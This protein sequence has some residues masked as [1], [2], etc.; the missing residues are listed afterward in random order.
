MAFDYKTNLHDPI[1]AALGVPAVLTGSTAVGSHDLVVIDR[2]VGLSVPT[3][4]VIEIQSVRPYCKVRMA[5][6]I[7]A[8][9]DLDDEDETYAISFNGKDWKVKSHQ[10][11][12]SPS[13]L[14]AGQVMLIL[15][16]P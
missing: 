11:I 12:P 6:I 16:K 14:D 9:I 5:E 1:Y 2:T 4:S 10:M 7:A 3:G 8:G 13:G 15:S